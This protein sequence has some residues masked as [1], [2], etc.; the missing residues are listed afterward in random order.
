MYKINRQRLIKQFTDLAKISSPSWQE[1]KVIEYIIDAL[2][3]LKIKYSKH[4]CGSSYNLLARLNGNSS[5]TPILFSCHMDTVTPCDDIKPIITDVKISSDGSTILGA[6]DKAAIA[7]FLESIRYIKEN[8]MEHGPIEFLFSCA[9]E[10]GLYGIKDFDLTKLKAKY[11]FVFDTGGRIGNIVIKAPYHI[12]MDVVIKG[13]AAHA[14]IEPE[15]GINAI[16]VASEI[17]SKIPHGRID[18][19][20]TVNL[21]TISGGKATNIVAEK[22]EFKLEARSISNTKLRKIIFSITEIIKKTSKKH[23]AKSV[24][25]KNLEY[26]G[27]SLNENAKI[28]KITD[29]AVHGIGLKPEYEISGGGSDTNVINKAGINA[30]NLS[31][32]M[33][34]V[35]TKKEHIFIKDLV[36]GTKLVL[37]IIENIDTL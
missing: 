30:V 16:R 14:G 26:S 12:T 22:A 29:K 27:F 17:I 2:K 37:S 15:K 32:G 7:A 23:R 9:E 3:S 19:E 36:N 11:A 35:H 5:I 13:K 31:I 8:N 1:E 18:N 33:R 20:T 10:T 6:D 28:I 34:N 24:I 21:G 25:D 4:K